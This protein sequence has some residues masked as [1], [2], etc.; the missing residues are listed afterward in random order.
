M[1]ENPVHRN[2]IC[3][4]GKEIAWASDVVTIEELRGQ[5]D[6]DD[7]VDIVLEGEPDEVLSHDFLTRLEDVLDRLGIAAGAGT[8]NPLL[9]AILMP[10]ATFL[11][12]RAIR[13]YR[14]EIERI[15]ALET[16][17]A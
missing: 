11:M 1:E 15:E 14:E 6:W 5:A 8:V 2:F 12:Y 10:L 3:L 7:G 16:A 4:E 9:A 13:P 17:P